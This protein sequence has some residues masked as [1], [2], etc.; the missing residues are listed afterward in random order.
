MTMG[1]CPIG[2]CLW[3]LWLKDYRSKPFAMV[4]ALIVRDAFGVPGSSTPP[5]LLEV[6]NNCTIC[7]WGGSR[8]SRFT[9]E[10]IIDTEIVFPTALNIT[11]CCFGGWCL[12][13]NLKC[14]VAQISITQA[15]TEINYM[16]PQRI[17]VPMAVMP[18]DKHNFQTLVIYL[19]STSPANIGEGN[20]DIPSPVEGS[21]GSETLILRGDS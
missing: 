9:L 6:I 19:L 4:S 20:G 1:P 17:V 15:L 10:G 7:R 16:L 21:V 2:V 8:I 14:I 3:T 5:G 12:F 18:L 11:A 13:P